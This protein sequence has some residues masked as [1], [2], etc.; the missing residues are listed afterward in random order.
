MGLVVLEA[1][2]EDLTGTMEQSMHTKEILC[3]GK[4]L[5][6]FFGAKGNTGLVGRLPLTKVDDN[7]L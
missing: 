5:C 7:I 3:H 2:G 4:A 6:R 1:L